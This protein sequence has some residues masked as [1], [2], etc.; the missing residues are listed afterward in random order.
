M[1]DMKSQYLETVTP[2][3]K[4][5]IRL[6]AVAPDELKALARGIILGA[7]LS[8]KILRSENSCPQD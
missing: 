4:E 1:V 3:D 7:N 5:F 8:E 6:L 2:E